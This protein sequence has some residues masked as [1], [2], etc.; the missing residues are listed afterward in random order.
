MKT[1]S[2]F[3]VPTIHLNGTSGERLLDDQIEIGK[4]LNNAIA[5]LYANGP[6]ARDYY[7]EG[8]FATANA[9]HLDRLKRLQTVYR[10]IEEIVNALQDQID[11][12]AVR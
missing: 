7:I 12:R 5:A 2:G 6:N 10:E 11:K 9:E 8:N 3:T 1:E 4:H